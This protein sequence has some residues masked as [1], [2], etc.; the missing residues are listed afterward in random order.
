MSPY[1]TPAAEAKTYGIPK[2][3]SYTVNA[4]PGG[5]PSMSAVIALFSQDGE[6]APP[7]ADT[8]KTIQQEELSDMRDNPLI[9]AAFQAHPAMVAAILHL[10]SLSE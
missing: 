10:E 9:E 4:N 3:L 6:Q 1:I 8:L 2:V 7:N 5:K